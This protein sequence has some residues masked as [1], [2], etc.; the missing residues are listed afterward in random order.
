M[1]GRHDSARVVFKLRESVASLDRLPVKPLFENWAA[2]EL[3]ALEERA[4]GGDPAY[5]AG[6]LSSTYV[7]ECSDRTS[8]QMLASSLR[9][10][11]HQWLAFAEV[12]LA[13]ERKGPLGCSPR[14]GLTDTP[15]LSHRARAP[16]GI[17][18]GAAWTRPGGRGEGQS[19]VDIERGWCLAHEALAEH[20]VPPPLSGVN[21]DD[22]RPHGTGSLGV[23][24]GRGPLRTIGIVP[25]LARLRVASVTRSCAPKQFSIAA[26]IIDVLRFVDFGDILVL[27]VEV[28]GGSES[29]YTTPVPAEALEAVFRAVRCATALGVTVVAAAG[30]GSRDLD[31]F[32]NRAF[33][34]EGR[35]SLAILVGARDSRTWRRRGTSNYGTRVDCFGPGDSV[36]SACAPDS[37]CSSINAYTDDFNGTSAATA[38]VAGAAAAVQG[39]ARARFGRRYGPRQLRALL[40]DPH[41]TPSADPAADK[42]GVM[43]NLKW[44]LDNLPAP[45]IRPWAPP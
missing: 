23:I 6:S 34:R 25:A 1:A 20:G 16:L 14:V 45:W 36:L 9:V 32:N 10:H 15:G 19:V 40:S 29:G 17:D 44:I 2:G 28:G 31:K 21:D 30:N 37:T 24:A 35:D 27:E 11:T 7:I 12:E 8:A 38:I 39:V 3:S 13:P 4:R 43:P 18:V 33:D 22:E 41:N 5:V 42:I 26:A